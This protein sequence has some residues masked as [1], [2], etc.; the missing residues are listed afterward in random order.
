MS[1][2]DN[3]KWF[4]GVDS[5]RFI[6][7]LIVMLSHFDDPIADHCKKSGSH[8]VQLFG[9]LLAN[10][11]NGTAAVIAFFII[12][13]FVIHYPNKNK[14]ID[15]KKFWIRRFSRILI[16]LIVIFFAGIKFNHPDQLVIW[17]LICELAYYAL[18]PLLAKIPGS[19]KQKF[20]AAFIISA[21]MICTLAFHELVAFYKQSNHMMQGYYWQFGFSLTWIVGLP[22]WLL[23]VVLAEHI[24][25]FKQVSFGKVA[26]YRIA[27]FLVSC[28]L[29][30]AKFH[31]HLSYILSMNIFAIALYKWL[32]AEIVYF[33]TRKPYIIFEHMGKFSYSL[34]LCHPIIYALLVLL[35]P[36]NMLTY[37]IFIILTI[38]I[39]YVFYL[40][41]ER[42]AHLFAVWASKK[43]A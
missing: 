3:S 20:I 24:D 14:T 41:V 29:G 15:L 12:S 28:I 34:Y 33:K 36:V 42:P 9:A 5:I 22:V 32:Q 6:L 4:K 7:A 30:F 26:I 16:P 1:K 13:G 10:A 27:I 31:L 25:N 2:P 37:P 35:I 17:S 43:V 38:I 18:Y 39:S 19:W 8:A 23:G 11:F 21:I 40:L